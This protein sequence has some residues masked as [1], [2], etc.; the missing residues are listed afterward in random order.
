MDDRLQG[1]P[2]RRGLFRIGFRQGNGGLR[3]LGLFAERFDMRLG[4]VVGRSGLI[5]GLRGF[6]AFPVQILPPV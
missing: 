1:R 6:N 5:I 4:R 3:R 2:P